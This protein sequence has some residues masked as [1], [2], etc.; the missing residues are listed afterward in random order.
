M[1]C[2][3][4]FVLKMLWH[5]LGPACNEQEDVKQIARYKRVLLLVKRFNTAISDFIVKECVRCKGSFTRCDVRLRFLR[6]RN[7]IVWLLMTM[8]MRCDLLCVQCILVCYVTNEWVPYLFCT[9]W[10]ISQKHMYKTA[11][12][13]RAN[14]TV[15]TDLNRIRYK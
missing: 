15:W 7:W 13:R 5:I 1:V 11:V 10:T 14:R 6:Y 3:I 12:A 8:F 9:V 2:R 4:Y